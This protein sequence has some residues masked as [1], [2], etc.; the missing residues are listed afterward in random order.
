MQLCVRFNYFGAKSYYSRLHFSLVVIRSRYIAAYRLRTRALSHVCQR[1]LLLA[2]KAECCC[3]LHE[4]VHS[5][6]FYNFSHCSMSFKMKVERWRLSEVKEHSL[7]VES[8]ADF[9][10]AQVSHEKPS[11]GSLCAV[12]AL[13]NR[14]S[15]MNGALILFWCVYFRDSWLNYYATFT[16]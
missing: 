14:I 12:T 16:Y 4:G 13:C 1:N 10:N 3:C 2:L 15:Q 9:N 8:S 6:D 5:V 7:L 11:D